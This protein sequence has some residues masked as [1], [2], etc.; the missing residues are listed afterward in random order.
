MLERNSF[1][2]SSDFFVSSYYPLADDENYREPGGCWWWIV[3]LGLW[4]S[5]LFI[6]YL[7]YAHFYGLTLVP[8]LVSLW[9]EPLFGVTYSFRFIWSCGSVNA[10]TP[11]GNAL[12]DCVGVCVCV[13]YS[14]KPCLLSFSFTSQSL[15]VYTF[16]KGG[17][18]LYAVVGGWVGANKKQ[19]KKYEWHIRDGFLCLIVIFHEQHWIVFILDHRPVVAGVLVRSCFCL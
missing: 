16:T 7:C 12:D 11:P 2:E 9:L 1:N 18:A 5:Q 13:F 3:R 4:W 14:S 8:P 10:D 17:C 15:D 19:K 6:A